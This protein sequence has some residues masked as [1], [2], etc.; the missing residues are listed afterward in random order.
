[1]NGTLKIFPRAQ[2]E[3][4]GYYVRAASPRGMERFT[5]IRWT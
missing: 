5:S 4:P 1:M 2:P 3:D